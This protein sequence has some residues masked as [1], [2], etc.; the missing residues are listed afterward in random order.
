MKHFLRFSFL[1]LLVFGFFVPRVKALTFVNNEDGVATFSVPTAGSG[2]ITGS[3]VRVEEEVSGDLFCAGR[4]VVIN[5][6][7]DGDVICAGQYITIEG[8]VTGNIRVAGQ[9]V[10]VL[11]TV[12]KNVTA[13]A[14]KLSISDTA[15]I[16]GELIT[17]GQDLTVSG[18]IQKDVLIGSNTAVL[19][20]KVGGNT[21]VY[22]ES[23]VVDDQASISGRLT[24]A[25]NESEIAEGVIA[26]GIDREQHKTANNRNKEVTVAKKNW[27]ENRLSSILIH[28]GLGLFLALLIPGK[29]KKTVA[30]LRG[31]PLHTVI[32]GFL[33]FV[34]VP[35]ILLLF[36]VT[37]IGIPVAFLAGMI[38]GLVV[39]F[40]RI[41]VAIYI[42]EQV[43]T[44]LYAKKKDQILW[45]AVVG[46]VTSWLAF[47]LP[48]IG[49]VLSFIA[50][51]WGTGGIMLSAYEGIKKKK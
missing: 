21:R 16:G 11:G 46:I 25:A 19:D 14:Q 37:I 47:G 7:V 6:T 15:V 4:D 44:A 29:I 43:L 20:G 49:W 45:Q 39:F 38:F 1:C 36:V 8:H 3:T 22:T 24:Y 5:T 9:H 28:L 31:R 48:F 18:L 30:T 40:S 12:D 34:F 10:S 35:L 26:G 50:I 2:F 23:L 41:V 27:S 33:S 13:F 17:A 42:G 51:L 32:I